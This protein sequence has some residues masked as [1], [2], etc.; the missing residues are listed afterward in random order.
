VQRRQLFF[1]LAERVIRALHATPSIEVVAVVT[2]SSEVTAFAKSLDAEV[3]RHA[4]DFGTASAF[5]SAVQHLQPL[6]LERLLMIAGDLPLVSSAALEQ[7]VAL[8]DPSAGVVVV[9]DRHRLGTNALLCAPPDVVAPCFGGDSFRLHLQAAQAAG[10]PAQV[11][12]VEEL[13]LDL[14]VAADFEFLRSQ[15]NVSA[16]QLIQA[17]Q[18]VDAPKTL[19]RCVA[20]VNR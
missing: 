2:A 19:T 12:E 9:P 4:A 15:E 8:A 14:D 11:L 20:G 17:L 6:K 5:A 16:L 10:V 13:A 18:Q 1:A 3:I 7:V